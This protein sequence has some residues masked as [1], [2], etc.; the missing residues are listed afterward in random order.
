MK[1]DSTV[2]AWG[3][4]EY[5]QLGQNDL[6]DYSSPV[7]IPGTAWSEVSIGYYREQLKA[8]GIRTNGTLWMWGRNQFGQ[9]GL[10]SQVDYSSPVQLPGTT[11][12]HY[13]AGGFNHS[14]ATRTDG[15]LWIWGKNN[16]GSLGQSQPVITAISSPVQIPGTTWQGSRFKLSSV[17]YNTL[18]VKT[19]GTLWVWGQNEGGQL[20]QNEGPAQNGYSSPVQIPGTTWDKVANVFYASYATK[21]D[22]TLWAWGNNDAGALGLNEAGENKSRSSPTQIP[23]TNWDKIRA[24]QS[25]GCIATK[26][27]GTLWAWGNNSSGRAGQNNVTQYSSPIQIPGSYLNISSA[28]DAFYLIKQG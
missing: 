28:E 11:W 16:V 24:G 9:L 21:T 13:Y 25:S 27:D 23:G 2:W 3:Y 15:T 26:T 19:D 17:S 7:Q 20:G 12:E 1:T 18:A 6:V 8:G 14:I 22:G 5:G 10:N 4:N